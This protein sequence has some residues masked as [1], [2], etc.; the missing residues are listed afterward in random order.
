MAVKS[1]VDNSENSGPRA[2]FE[3]GRSG[4]LAALVVGGTRGG[5]SS[6]GARRRGKGAPCSLPQI[7]KLAPC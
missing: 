3:K 2:A 6:L 5:S 4:N 7:P 1:A